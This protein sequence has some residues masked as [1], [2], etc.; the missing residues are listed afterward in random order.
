VEGGCEKRENRE[1]K[2]STEEDIKGIKEYK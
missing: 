1:G 2:G